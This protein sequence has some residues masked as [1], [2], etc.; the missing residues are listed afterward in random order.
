MAQILVENGE[1]PW[2]H[3][4]CVHALECVQTGALN[5]KERLNLCIMQMVVL[6]GCCGPAEDCC[7]EEEEMPVVS[8]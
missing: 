8:A 4:G 5:R 6:R 1:G 3:T 7:A 2:G